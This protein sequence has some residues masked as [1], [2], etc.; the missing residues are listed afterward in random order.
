MK[1]AVIG[2]SVL[3]QLSADDSDIQSAISIPI[4]TPYGETSSGFTQLDLNGNN[5]IY[6]NRHGSH[7]QFAPHQVNYRANMYALKEMGVTHIIASAAVGGIT[8]NMPPL[9]CVIPDQL[10]DYS[11]SREQTYNDGTKAVNHIDFSYPF[12]ESLRQQLI[13]SAQTQKIDCATQAT[14]GVTQGPRLETVAEINRLQRDG[15]HIVGMT[16][17]PEAALARELEMDYASC[18][19]VVNWAAG[20]VPEPESNQLS[21]QTSQETISMAEIIAN[22]KRGDQVLQKLVK[23]VLI[24]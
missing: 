10:I 3:S 2:G 7:H 13:V 5:V 19:I 8:P 18:A 24:S 14:Y 12:T 16:L 22:V 21:T 20:R 6:F 23:Q 1:Y 15:C 9:Q 17:M 11:Y 4:K